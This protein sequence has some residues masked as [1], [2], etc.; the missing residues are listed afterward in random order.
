MRPSRSSL[1]HTPNQNLA[2]YGS[3]K[4]L[5]FTESG[6]SSNPMAVLCAHGLA[7]FSSRILAEKHLD[8]LRRGKFFVTSKIVSGWISSDRKPILSALALV[9][10]IGYQLRLPQ[11]DHVPNCVASWMSNPIVVIVPS[12]A[13][14]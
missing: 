3:I 14:S 9:V 4:V 1:H 5:F 12:S 7:A 6:N 11:R 8:Q 10:I 13:L 2:S